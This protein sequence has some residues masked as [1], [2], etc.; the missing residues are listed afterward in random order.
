MYKLNE[1]EKLR[2]SA[3]LIDENIQYFDEILAYKNGKYSVRLY[4]STLYNASLNCVTVT[5]TEENQENLIKINLLGSGQRNYEAWK[6]DP[7]TLHWDRTPLCLTFQDLIKKVAQNPLKLVKTNT[8][9][10]LKV[11][12]FC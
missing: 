6:L 12:E 5:F 10:M 3:S 8:L 4:H 2:Q 9:E 11:R 7:D 1:I